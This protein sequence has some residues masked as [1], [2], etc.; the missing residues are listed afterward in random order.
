MMYTGDVFC[1]SPNKLSFASV[2]SWKAIYEFSPPGQLI[3]IKSK[4]YK[5]YGA[6]FDSLCVGSKRD[7]KTHNCIKKLLLGAFSIK[8]LLEQEDIIQKCVDQFVFRLDKNEGL[9]GF[10]I[11]KWYK[12][13]AFDILGEMAFGESF[14]CIEN[15]VPPN[16]FNELL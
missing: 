11:T 10:N 13:I 4:F 14:H 5:M 9:R 15:G 1:V 6:G 7:P 8:V 12:M 2:S 16:C 3:L